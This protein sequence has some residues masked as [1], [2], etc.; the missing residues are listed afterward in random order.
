[1]PKFLGT[2][3][4]LSG[5]IGVGGVVEQTFALKITS[6]AGCHALMRFLR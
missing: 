2:T 3:T 5:G 4:Y 1:M 6:I